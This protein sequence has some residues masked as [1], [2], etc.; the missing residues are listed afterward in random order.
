MR[1]TPTARAE[2]GT[3]SITTMMSV[4]AQRIGE[5]L[6]FMHN[7]WSCPMQILVSLALLLNFIG[8][9]ALGGAFLA[10]MVLFIEGLLARL[11]LRLNRAV[12]SATDARMQCMSQTVKNIRSIKAYGWQ[13]AFLQRILQSRAVEVSR[14]RIV[15]LVRAVIVMLLQATPVLVSLCTFA[16]YTYSNEV[17]ITPIQVLIS[18]QSDQFDMFA[19]MFG[20]LLLQAFT[21]LSLFALLR[22]P[23]T[24]MPKVI[25]TLVDSIASFDRLDRFMRASE[26]VPRKALAKSQELCPGTITVSRVDVYFDFDTCSASKPFLCNFD[27]HCAPG[28]FTVCVGP[29]ASGKSSLLLTLLSELDA[30]STGAASEFSVCGSIAYVAQQT[31]IPNSTVRSAICFGLPFDAEWYNRVLFACALQTDIQS[32]S[33]G[34]LTEIGERGLNLSGG[35]KMRIALAR[36]V[37]SRADIYLLDAPLSAL[38]VH[39]GQHV[40]EHC[41]CTLL[42]GRTVVLVTHQLE[43]AQFADQII[44]MKGADS[45]DNSVACVTERGTF[46]KLMSCDSMFRQM[47]SEQM[48]Q[49]NGTHSHPIASKAES[50]GTL[51]IDSSLLM[52]ADGSIS[53]DLNHSTARG[54]ASLEMRNDGSLTSPDS[55]P[56]QNSVAL[57]IGGEL[58]ETA[59]LAAGALIVAETRFKGENTSGALELNVVV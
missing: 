6:L 28:S 50:R 49:Q 51:A 27:F 53:F 21:S 2:I 39:V 10:G 48:S 24:I 44:V 8:P 19:F 15:A 33:A 20:R 45:T 34:D 14:L 43:A 1:L 35:Q 9:A 7:V 37:Y 3:G 42:R 40:L 17:P 23:L 41:I 38:D 26:L 56:D 4:D 16:I 55:R 13:S 46:A 58:T 31:W 30:R 12:L 29:I 47:Y 57:S 59:Q 36:A 52:F 54:P 5:A 18:C 11:S 32:F 22:A 25:S